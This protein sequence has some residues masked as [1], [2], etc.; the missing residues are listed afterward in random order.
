MF[1]SS[2]A[3]SSSSSPSAAA[4]GGL[5]AVPEASG[6]RGDGEGV[7]KFNEDQ[8][9]TDEADEPTPEELAAMDLADETLKVKDDILLTLGKEIRATE[10]ELERRIRATV[11]HVD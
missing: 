8:M 6:E 11:A 3:S 7:T 10:D 2:G 4:K 9:I 1:R 5:S